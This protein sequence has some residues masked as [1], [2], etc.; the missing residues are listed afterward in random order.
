MKFVSF[1]TF[2]ILAF[3]SVSQESSACSKIA[4]IASAEKIVNDADVVF[5]GIV[6][7]TDVGGRDKF[8]FGNFNSR[9]KPF[10]VYKGWIPQTISVRG[11]SDD[12]HSNHYSFGVG[13]MILVVADYD[14]ADGLKLPY[15]YGE[16]DQKAIV[17]YLEKGIG[18]HKSSDCLARALKSVNK[19]D[20][21]GKVQ[22]L[23]DLSYCFKNEID[24]ANPFRFI[25]PNSSANAEQV[26]Q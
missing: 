19:P 5:V 23:N 17:S 8:I 26:N 22:P 7:Q 1:I 16:L 4:Y 9:V 18:R 21:N 12:C 15:F 2:F 3:L 25:P 13:K 20:R 6:E 24:K 10:K 11:Y 14:K